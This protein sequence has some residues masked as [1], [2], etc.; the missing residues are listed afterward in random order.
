MVAAPPCPPSPPV[1]GGGTGEQEVVCAG[2]PADLGVEGAGTV[3]AGA[4][5]GQGEG[6]GGILPHC[7]GVVA[8]QVQ[9][10]L[11]PPLS[12][13]LPLS[14]LLVLAVRLLYLLL[15][16]L[17]Q[18]VQSFHL[19][20]PLIGPGGVVDEGELQQGAEDEEHAGPAP[21]VDGLGVGNRG[22]RPVHPG[23][24]G[25]HGQQGR[26]PQRHPGRH[27]PVVQPEGDP[28]DDDQH[29]GGNVDGEQ[30]VRELALE[31]ED[32]LETTVFTW[33][34]RGSVVT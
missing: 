18:G 11:A 13:S 8:V 25:G 21:D 6:A 27:R 29:A 3:G 16:H 31:D 23:Y 32:N 19:P 9:L 4:G 2:Q 22:E 1:L 14:L 28:G 33:R 7:G 10:G 34:E 20:L 26:H 17:S 30:V 12:L 15:H 24:L 5:V